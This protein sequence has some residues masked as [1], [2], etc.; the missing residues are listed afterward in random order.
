MKQ[1]FYAVR[2][3]RTTGIFLTWD[4]CKASIHGFAGA[5]YKS[6]PTKKEAEDFLSSEREK[7]LDTDKSINDPMFFAKHDTLVAF[8]DGSFDAKT[9]KYAFGCVIIEPDGN[10]TEKNGEGSE[11]EAVSARNVAGELLATMTATAFAL[12]NGYKKLCIYHD[13]TGIARWYNGD[14]KAESFAA[15]EYLEFMNKTKPL[16][17][18][19]FIKVEA[20]TGVF[21][22]ERADILAKQALGIR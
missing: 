13:Y 5:E 20:H 15:K 3:G 11:P 2:S 14:W 10:V 16:L 8:V 7:V 9:K 22:N 17:Q 19:E 6:F 18:T 12:K 1:K 4:E 21:F